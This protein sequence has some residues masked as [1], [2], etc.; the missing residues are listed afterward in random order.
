MRGVDEN[1]MA[2]LE[3]LNFLF[4]NPEL[5]MSVR[6]SAL[7]SGLQTRILTVPDGLVLSVSF[8]GPPEEA[9]SFELAI[10]TYEARLKGVILEREVLENVAKRIARRRDVATA[11]NSGLAHWLG[12]RLRFRLP[13]TG[14]HANDLWR[15]SISR[16]TAPDVQA[17][18]RELFTPENTIQVEI[19]PPA[20]AAKPVSRR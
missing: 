14:P 16:V 7:E 19:S 4:E 9:R 1:R 10:N 5:T 13:F 20:P 2:A 6:P 18:A 11:T 3:V 8:Q 15:A 12:P 17:M